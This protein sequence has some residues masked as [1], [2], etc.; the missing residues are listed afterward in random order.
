MIDRDYAAFGATVARMVSDIFYI[1][2]TDEDVWSDV[3]SLIIESG[4]SSRKVPSSFYGAL[5]VEA[6]NTLQ[7]YD[8]PLQTMMKVGHII[9]AVAAHQKPRIQDD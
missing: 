4:S 9:D 1:N 2:P 7:P 6:S 8:K 3:N 5:T